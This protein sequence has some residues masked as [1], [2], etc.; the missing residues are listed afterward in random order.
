MTPRPTAVLVATLATAICLAACGGSR[1]ESTAK[2]E[3]TVSARSAPFQ[4][5]SGRGPA[6]LRLAEFGSEASASDRHEVQST[7][8]SYLEASA[9]GEWNRACGYVSEV[10]IGESDELV[11]QQP[12]PRPGCGEVLRALAESSDRRDGG[13]PIGA[14]E[15]IASLRIKEGPGGGFALFHGDDDRDYW[16]PVRRD[17]DG[18]KVLS[19]AP[20]PFG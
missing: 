20:Q 10:L 5:Y 13:A 6:K 1:E 7:L 8:D 9:E 14:P 11:E 15:G 19:A 18:W 12:T 3:E 2:V 16:I 4:K 17:S